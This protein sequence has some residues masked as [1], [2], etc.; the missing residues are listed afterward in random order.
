MYRSLLILVLV[1]GIAPAVFAGENPDVAIALHVQ[2]PGGDCINHPVYDCYQIV[3]NWLGPGQTLDFYVFVCGHGWSPGSQG[4]RTA[5]YGLL[6]PEDWAFVSWRTCVTFPDGETHGT[7]AQPGDCVYQEFLECQPPLGAP[8]AVGILTLLPT[9]P[10]AVSVIPHGETCTAEVGDCFWDVDLVLPTPMGNGRAGR[11]GVGLPG[12]GCNPCPCVGDPCYT[13]LGENPD[14]AI[15]LHG[16]LPGFVCQDHPVYDCFQIVTAIS[17]TVLDFFVFVCGQG[18][19]PESHGFQSAHYGLAWTE[20]LSFVSW[21]PCADYTYG[22]IQQE[23][24]GVYQLWYDSARSARWLRAFS[25][26]ER[27]APAG[28]ACSSIPA[29]GVPASGTAS[30]GPTSSILRRSA[31][32]AAPDGWT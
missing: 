20:N 17:G 2:E 27:T 5:R 21:V 6:W 12:A 7:I 11:V 9:S 18:W 23:G 22:T 14:G 31:A 4:F 1:L 25:R 29:A 16:E 8:V 15:A 28:S 24:D 10:G 3:T 13:S 30:A 26:C 19:N 32:T